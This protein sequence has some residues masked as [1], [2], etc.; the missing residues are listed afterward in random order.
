LTLVL[1]TSPPRSLFLNSVVPLINPSTISTLVF[2]KYFNKPA[3][4]LP[5]SIHSLT[6]GLH[7][8]QQGD[9]LPQLFTL[10]VLTMDLITQSITFLL[11]FQNSPCMEYSINHWTTFLCLFRSSRFVTLI[12][13]PN[14]YQHPLGPDRNAVGNLVSSENAVGNHVSS[15]NTSAVMPRVTTITTP[16]KFDWVAIF[17]GPN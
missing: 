14:F 15:A 8:D 1:I 7:F 3:D 2:G 12:S 13:I 5:Q 9:H 4:H 11:T 17:Q 16:G 6:F 10:L